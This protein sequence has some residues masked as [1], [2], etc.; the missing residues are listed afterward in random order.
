MPPALID[1]NI[2]IY[3]CDPRDPQRQERAIQ[4]L[5]RLDL[6]SEGRLSVQVL[7]EFISASTRSQRP[8]YT[9]AEALVQVERLL[10]TYPVYDLTPL[11]VLEAARGERDHSLSYYDAQIWA[12]A[13]LNQT[14]VIF[15]EDFQ[16][17]QV[18]EGVQFINPF[19]PE[20][21]LEAWL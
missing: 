10:Q 11:V 4:L 16:H 17:G 1:T 3:A 21:D 8:L 13:R 18:L 5:E 20:F 6:R 12:T 15:S 19:R 9:Y 7:A 14:L 2:L